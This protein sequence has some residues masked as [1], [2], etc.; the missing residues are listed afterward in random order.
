MSDTP[1]D[2]EGLHQ[3]EAAIG[4][5]H[6]KI[7]VVR[8]L[9]EPLVRASI[10]SLRDIHPGL[11]LDA[12]FE[13]PS[14]YHGHSEFMR[15]WPMTTL[16]GFEQAFP[17]PNHVQLAR[18]SRAVTEATPQ[19]LYASRLMLRVV[20]EAY[21]EF[22]HGGRSP[23]SPEGMPALLTHFVRDLA[24]WTDLMAVRGYGL[25]TI[26][27]LDPDRLSSDIRVFTET[28]EAQS[29]LAWRLGAKATTTAVM[30]EDFPGRDARISPRVIVGAHGN[31]FERILP[32]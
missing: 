26:A 13:K 27:Y 14:N 32:R 11:P 22:V 4:A 19:P 20:G 17:E 23:L 1:T 12:A 5:V 21:N 10:D 18:E 16:V 9:A 25:L 7:Q 29:Y 6:D 31:V 30:R 28:S 15:G 24:T 8:G 3:L 2:G